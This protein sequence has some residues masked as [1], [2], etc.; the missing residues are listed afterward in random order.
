MA[1]GG[2]LGNGTLI[3]V[4]V[5]GSPVSWQ[6]IPQLRE[7]AFPQD[8]SDRVEITTH[9]RTNKRKRY[10]T[11]LTETS[12]PSF[13]ILDDS[14][15]ATGTVQE[16]LR[17]IAALGTSVWW[18]IEKPTNRARTRFRGIEFQASIKDFQQD[19]PIEGA[20]TTRVT[21]T[22][23]GEDIGYTPAGASAF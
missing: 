1:Q 12:D 15:E 23:D 16:S 9:S 3:A 10:M 14:D 13:L 17:S 21:L 19:T 5:T 7:V 20:Q 18:R 11:G 6:V 22:F 2:V 8:T 4:S